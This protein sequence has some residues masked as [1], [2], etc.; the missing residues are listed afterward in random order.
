[1]A[2]PGVVAGYWLEPEQDNTGMS[3]IVFESQDAADA[4]AQMVQPG[5]HPSQYVTVK[6]A[7]VREVVAQV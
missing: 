1:M 7:S 4:A 6:S 2:A 3:I 5:S